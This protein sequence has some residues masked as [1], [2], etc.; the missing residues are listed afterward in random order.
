MRSD[1]DEG[2]HGIGLY[3]EGMVLVDV[4]EGVVWV[5]VVKGMAL[6]GALLCTTCYG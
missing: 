1:M 5:D 4:V 6:F 3:C 2:R